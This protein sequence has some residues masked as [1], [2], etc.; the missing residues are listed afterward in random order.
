MSF[1]LGRK[2]YVPN[3]TV[4]KFC[5]IGTGDFRFSFFGQERNFIF[6]GI[7]G[8][9]RKWKMHFR[10]ASTSNGF[11]LHPTSMI[12]KQQSRLR[13]ACRCL[14]CLEKLVLPSIFDTSHPSSS[15]SSSRSPSE[16]LR[17]SVTSGDLRSPQRR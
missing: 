1:A 9:G 14:R 6:V 4:T 10:S 16:P 3:W 11:R 17:R 15:S 5:D 7:F 12:F 13:T 2:C 8:Y